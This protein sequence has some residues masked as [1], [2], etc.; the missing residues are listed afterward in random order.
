M[1]GSSVKIVN[2]IKT[3]IK[4]AAPAPKPRP[5]SNNYGGAF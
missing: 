1:K 3:A 2:S 5:L 4:A